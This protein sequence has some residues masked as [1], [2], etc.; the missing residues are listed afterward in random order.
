MLQGEH[1]AIFLTFIEIPFSIKTV[2][3]SILKWPLKTGF[4]VDDLT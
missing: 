1:S 3:L 4:A 2:V